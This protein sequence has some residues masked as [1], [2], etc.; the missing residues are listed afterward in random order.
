MLNVDCLLFIFDELLDKKSLRSCLL[1]NREWCSLV[2]PI[3]WKLYSWYNIEKSIVFNKTINTILSCLPISSKQI[4]SDNNIKLPSTILLKPPLFNYISFCE[5][6]SSEVINKITGFV[7]GNF[8]SD[9]KINCFEREIYKLFIGRITNVKELI[10]QTSQPISSFPG[11]STCFSQ[12]NNLTIDLNYVDS[13]ALFVMSQICK[14]LDFLE[15]LHCSHDLPGL[16]SLIDAQRNLKKVHLYTRRGTCKELSKALARKGNTINVLYLNLIS[17]I[18]PSFLISLV[19]LT[20]IAIY[21]D[22]NNEFTDSE[23]NKFQQYLSISE[24][25][26]LQSLSVIG[27]SCFKELAMLIE[28]TNGNISRIHIDTTNRFAQNTGMLIKAIV[29]SCPIIK[30]L[31]TYLEPKDF[32]H[33][34]SL[35]IKCRHLEEIVFDNLNIFVND[36]GDEL[37]DILTKYSPMSLIDISISSVWKCSID[38]FELF[39]ESCR[40]RTLLNFNIIYNSKNYITE[41]HRQVVRRYIHEG[42]IRYSNCN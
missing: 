42:V 34:K 5:F 21:N 17:N 10:W 6:P 41:N 23:I 31:T 22:E 16:I 28:K 11:A 19:N 37:F 29:K 32:I 12:L 26:N 8:N 39:F 13:K 9:D 18:P 4:L 20:H 30:K 1:V 24:F 38:V 27:L 35:L 36:I 33:V 3:L 40:E 15:I 25:P 2:A 14:T 7:L